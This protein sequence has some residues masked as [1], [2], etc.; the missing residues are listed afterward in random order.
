MMMIKSTMMGLVMLPNPL[1]TPVPTAASTV[2]AV[3]SS[4]MISVDSVSIPLP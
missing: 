3:L 1:K 4:F 2:S